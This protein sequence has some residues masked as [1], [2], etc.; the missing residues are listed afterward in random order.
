MQAA[1]FSPQKKK[2]L[3][4]A[5]H[6]PPLKKGKKQEEMPLCS[7]SSIHIKSVEFRDGWDRGWV[8]A[9]PLDSLP[10]GHLFHCA[11]DTTA[12][13]AMFVGFELA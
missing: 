9:F 5:C 2:D 12:N 7:I 1:K 8:V 11:S 10:R 4:M 6:T 13:S 3:G